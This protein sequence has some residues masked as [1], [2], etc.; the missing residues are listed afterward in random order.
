MQSLKT[1]WFASFT[2]R[3]KAIRMALPNYKLVVLASIVYSITSFFLRMA[4]VFS[5]SGDYE[6]IY[7]EDSVNE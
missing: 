2:R 7:F 4:S 6:F 3:K 5:Y 1:G